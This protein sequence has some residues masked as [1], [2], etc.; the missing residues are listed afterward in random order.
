MKIVTRLAIGLLLMLLG[1][2]VLGFL[3]T[4]SITQ[5]SAISSDIF[6]YPFAVTTAILN[7]RADVLVSEKMASDLVSKASAAET[8][9]LQQELSATTARIDKNM[10][11]VRER[12][13]GNKAELT[14]VDKALAAWH[15]ARDETLALA[16]S[17]RRAEATALND[18][19]DA[20]LVDVVFKEVSDVADFSAARAAEL[21][22]AALKERN[23]ALGT[24]AFM[25][26]MIIAGGAAVAFL[27]IRSVRQSLKL[28]VGTVHALIADS[29]DKVLAAQAVG[30]GDLSREI[31]VSEPLQMDLDAL[32]KDELGVLM[33]TAFHLSEVQCALDEAFLHMTRSLRLARENEAA[34]D[35][36]KSGRNELNILIRE[37]QNTAEMAD[38]VLGF[39]VTHLSAGMG[40]FYLFD[41]RAVRLSLTATYAARKD[42]KLGEYFHLG[43]GA[44]G[45]AART[46]KIIFLTDLPPDYLPI[47]SALGTSVPKIVVA[48]PL[49]HG[50]RLVG[51]IE[52]ATFREFSENELKF[53][54]IARETIAIAIDANLA[55]QR[56]AELLEQTEQQAEELRVQ[57]EELQQSNEELE[58]RA[59][60]LEQQRE[61]I[62]LKNHEIEAASRILHEKVA[63][64]ERVSTYKSEFLANMSHELRTPLNSLMILSSL[65]KQNKDG[66]L[67]DKQVEFAATINSAGMDLLNLINDILDLSK[68]EAGQMQF[69]CAALPVPD[70]CDSIRATFEPLAE[71]KG[72]AFRVETDT[73]VPATFHGDEQRVHQVLKNLLSNA[74]KFTEKGEVRLRI[75]IPAAQENPLPVPA[76]A[77]I[78]SDTGIGVSAAKQQLVFEAFQQ[79]DGSISRKYGGTGLGLSISLQLAHRMNGDI[80][81]SSEEGKGSVFTLYMPLSA[82]TTEVDATT[83]KLAHA[84]PMHSPRQAPRPSVPAPL[85]AGME[86]EEPPPFPAPLPDDRAQLAAGDKC[87]LIIED[88][89]S[90]A[91]ILQGMVKERGFDALVASDG[92]SGIAMARRFLPSAVILD[93]M[94]PHIDGWGVMRS[95]KDNPRTRHIPVH[96]V[97]CLEDRQKA[98]AMGA[99]GFA[100]KPVSMEQINDVLQSIEGSLAKSVRKLLIVED[101]EDEAKSMV[102]LLE[103]DGVDIVVAVT[104]RDAIRLLASQAFDCMVLD[105]GLSDMSGFELL[106]Y[107]QNMEGAR[108]IPV[109]IH[110]GRELTHEDE[111]KLRR[112]AESIII[113]GAKSPERLLNEVTLFLHLVESNLHPNKQR[114]IRTAIDKEAMLEGRKVLLV[115]DDMRNIFS[116]SS[117]LAEKNMV[118]IEAEN[119]REALARLEDHHDISIILMDIM[120]PE[121]D[122][123]AAMREIR[124]NPRLVNIP[125]IAMTAKALRGDQ[126][127]CMAA[128]ASD[129][130]AKPIEVDKL[131]SLIRV[132]IFQHI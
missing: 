31:V 45:Q 57:Q 47:G 61:N 58:E 36:L 22:D 105:L 21:E 12:F 29:A 68:V 6:R 128:G 109:I 18:G 14:R 94:L 17:G 79:A 16:R 77:F 84:A 112:F 104:G 40:A 93:V 42:M 85:P 111:R 33:K 107:I 129:Y 27:V 10:A 65:L 106:E 81:M 38:E 132:W 101:N 1:L 126:Q 44:I 66:N 87:I 95:L 76:L 75:V 103:E 89:L 125:I 48:I 2:L 37:E 127:K 52:I 96:F 92:E 55:H 9:Q 8:G 32:P 119:G 91:S 102:A 28:A 60:M 123:Y 113:K 110:S 116:L 82:A 54:E 121:M 62:R 15:A 117:V 122:G 72:L 24:I 108:R 19:R 63:E 83:P 5:L 7:V 4:R 118:V 34:R 98:M 78:V 99:I 30:A 131:L 97:T 50:N 100:T 13:L 41:E 90:F 69:N 67:S 23:A 20:R 49:L 70:L 86:S 88:D 39:L 115:D 59:Q 26:V 43:E 56:T 130:I 80:R 46:Q 74:L 53:L 11:T 51:V 73:G 71:Q 120:M 25:L 64:L 3:G 35:W 124:K 114:M